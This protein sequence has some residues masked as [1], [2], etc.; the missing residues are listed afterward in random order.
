MGHLGNIFGFKKVPRVPNE[1]NAFCLFAF[2]CCCFVFLRHKSPQPQ[3]HLE[4][5]A[6]YSSKLLDYVLACLA[7]IKGV[8]V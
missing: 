1:P 8:F 5:K 3:E 2:Y 6:A 7:F 4:D